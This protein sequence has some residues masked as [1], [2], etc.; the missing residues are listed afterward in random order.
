MYCYDLE[1]MSSNPSWVEL[2]VYIC[3]VLLPKSHL[4]QKLPLKSSLTYIT[5]H[6]VNKKYSK[7]PMHSNSHVHRA[8]IFILANP[9][10][11]VSREHSRCSLQLSVSSLCDRLQL[12]LDRL[13]GSCIKFC[14]W[15]DYMAIV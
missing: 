6:A 4:I 12:A 5:P 7:C 1:I 9:T 13:H 15:T 11:Q 10:R 3:V 14:Y 2:G 8:G